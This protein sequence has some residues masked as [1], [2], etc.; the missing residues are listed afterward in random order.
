MFRESKELVVRPVLDY[1]AEARANT[2]KT[3]QMLKTVEII[4]LWKITGK[5]IDHVR[6]Q[7]IR[8]QCEIQPIGEWVENA[9]K[10]GIITYQE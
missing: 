9:D 1:A 4:A 5:R 8:Q 2:C 6:S 7:V 3:E 10:Y